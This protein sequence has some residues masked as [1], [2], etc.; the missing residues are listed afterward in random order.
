MEII[1]N[2]EYW[3]DEF[4]N[5]WLKTFNES[6]E[7]D[8]KLYKR[9][10]NET[11]P[12]VEGI[13]LSK[14][15]LM[16][17]STAGGYLPATQEP[18]DAENDYGDYSIRTFSINTPFSDIAYAHTHYD[19]AAIDADPQVLLPLQHLRNMVDEGIIGELAESVV[20]FGGYQPDF[21][22]VL[23]ETIPPIIEIAK[24]E[25]VDGALLVPA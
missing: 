12:G 25:K 2:L 13:D 23:E 10:K 1:E 11:A 5:G 16:L 18:F 8:W 21:R 14:S 24:K 15:K 4:E 9:P 20:S 19:H 22:Q 3:S 17:I 7:I 6:G